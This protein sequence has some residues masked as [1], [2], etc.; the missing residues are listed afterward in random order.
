MVTTVNLL[1]I[2]SEKIIIL[3]R[4]LVIVTV[5][6]KIIRILADKFSDISTSTKKKIVT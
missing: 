1:S 6:T 4:V 3:W 2:R 5:I